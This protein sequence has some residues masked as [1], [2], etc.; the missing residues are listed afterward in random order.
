MTLKHFFL[1]LIFFCMCSESWAIDAALEGRVK[2]ESFYIFDSPDGFDA[3]DSDAELRLGFTGNVWKQ[4]RLSLDYEI[5]GDAKYVDGPRVQTG[6]ADEFDADFFR[7]WLRLDRGNVRLRGGRQKILFGAGNIFRPLGFFDTRDISGIVPETKGVDGGRI[8]YFFDET[9]SVQGWAVPGKRDDHVI[10]GG[11][12]EAL[13]KE[14]E[15]GVVMQYHPTTALDDL[16]QFDQELIQL[17]FHLKGERTVGYWN[18]SRL[19]IEQK[20]GNH[21]LR[22][23]SVF[24]VDYTFAIGGGLHVLGEYFISTREAGFTQSRLQGDDRTIHQLGI[25]LDQ[26]VGIA[27]VWRVFGFYDV[28]DGSFQ[29]I[30]QIE[31]AA[32]NQVYLYLSG[33]I[34]EDIIG[35]DRDGRLFRKAPVFTGTESNIGLAVVVYF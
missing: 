20:H 29:I 11:R 27:M 15:T 25:L 17:G 16:P 14:I 3:V 7:A 33:Q 23:D 31:Y 24:G 13:I 2:A 9:T 12:W 8:T 26:P 21:P 19:D 6:F 30:P 1:I 34:G 22:F 35:G 28:L 18:E 4:E 32:T 10:I 5:S